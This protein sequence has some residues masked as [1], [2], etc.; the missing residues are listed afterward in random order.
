MRPSW[1]SNAPLTYPCHLSLDLASDVGAVSVET[2]AGP[3]CSPGWSGCRSFRSLADSVLGFQ[4]LR[5]TP[6]LLTGAAGLWAG[7]WGADSQA[8]GTHSMPLD[9][10]TAS[11]PAAFLIPSLLRTLLCPWPFLLFCETFRTCQMAW[12]PSSSQ[13]ADS[14]T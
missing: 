1:P 14:L 7:G 11:N 4:P 5:S 9:Y 3:A 13:A 8:S 6:V 12:P 2:G 10:R